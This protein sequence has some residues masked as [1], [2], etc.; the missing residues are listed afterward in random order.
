[1]NPRWS[2]P[3]EQLQT[4]LVSISLTHAWGPIVAMVLMVYPLATL[5]NFSAYF[6]PLSQQYYS[7]LH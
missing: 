3:F 5:V 7:C 6:K 1:M 2:N 4:P